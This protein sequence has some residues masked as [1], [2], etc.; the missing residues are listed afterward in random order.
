MLGLAD[1]IGGNA[2][3]VC[4]LVGDDHRFG[5]SRNHIDAH[6]QPRTHL[7]L[8]RPQR[9]PLR[10]GEGSDVSM[11]FADVVEQRGCERRACG[12]D[13]R[14]GDN[15]RTVPLVERSG[16]LDCFGL[17]AFAQPGE[18]ASHLVRDILVALCRAG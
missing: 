8:E 14:L 2:M 10:L 12:S 4:G 9:I 17:S 16:E 5:G 6:S 15:D 13:G 3:G 7:D 1:E 11:G 18:H